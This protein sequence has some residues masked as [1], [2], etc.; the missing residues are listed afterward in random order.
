MSLFKSNCNCFTI[1]Q[2][3]LD[4]TMKEIVKPTLSNCLQLCQTVNQDL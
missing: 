4:I 2:V 1:S 3:I